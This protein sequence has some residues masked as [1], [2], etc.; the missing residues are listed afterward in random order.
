M[1]QRARW[2][3]ESLRDE[4]IIND[5]YSDNLSDVPDDICS[6]SDT[7]SGSDKKEVNV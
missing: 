1:A 5:L 6:E 2:Y 3:H 7:A 4:E